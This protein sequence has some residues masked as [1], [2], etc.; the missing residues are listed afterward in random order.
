MLLHK[1]KRKRSSLPQQSLKIIMK[2]QEKEVKAVASSFIRIHREGYGN[3]SELF[4]HILINKASRGFG[5]LGFWGL[6]FRV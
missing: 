4:I 5:V 6:G 2:H 3:A 1:R